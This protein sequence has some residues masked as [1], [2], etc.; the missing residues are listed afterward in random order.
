MIS[1]DE[2]LARIRDGLTPLGA[3][4]VALSDAHGRVL[5]EDLAARRTQPPFAVS[6]MDGYAVRAADVA[7]LPTRLK[8][9]GYIQAGGRHEGTVGPGETVRIFTGARLPDGADSVVIQED[10]EAGDGMVL[11]RD[12]VG[13]FGPGRHVRQAG[14]DFV[15]GQ[16]GLTAGRRLTARDVGLAA[17]MNRPWLM[18]HRRPRVAILPT[19]DEVAL[20]GD[21]IGPNQI[22]S[23]NGA[24]LGALV[25][26]A[27]GLPIHL[28]IARDDGDTLKTM[29]R[30]AEG[31]D[32]LVTIGGASVGEHDL[33]RK[34]LGEIGL[35]VDFWKIAMRPG[36]PLMFGRLGTTAVLGL[37]GNPVSALVCGMLF[38]RP[39]L[40]RLQG[41]PGTGPVA[42]PARAGVELKANDGRQDYLRARLSRD[43]DGAL[44]A[45]PFARQD[46]SMMSALAGADCLILRPP[47]AAAVPTGG[48]VKVIRLSD[49][50]DAF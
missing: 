45:T 16:V 37:P 47:S 14:I 3:E 9:V 30:G 28:G 26:A 17:A 50:T 43:P 41:L 27:G 39:A 11:V 40:D 33:V 7:T 22:V 35:A 46:S 29:A 34:A 13:E 19:G 5:A 31:A 23:S 48:A 38:L 10:T 2:A 15:E 8:L 44:I 4:Q 36:K 1:V 42:E 24:A 25:A 6:A 32:L 49:G 21:P 12:R 18:V 20:P